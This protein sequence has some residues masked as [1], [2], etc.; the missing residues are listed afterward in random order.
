M[1]N[2]TAKYAQ[3]TSS[4]NFSPVVRLRR[5][6]VEKTRN[7]DAVQK[8]LGHQNATYSMHY[9]QRTGGGLL[10]ILNDQQLFFAKKAAF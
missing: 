1:E 8:Q 4:N 7:D 2:R 5:G 10:D 6:L 3:S 9:V